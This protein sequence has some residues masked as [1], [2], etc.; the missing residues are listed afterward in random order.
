[1]IILAS[2]DGASA[3]ARIKSG[4][5][6]GRADSL[7]KFSKYEI[8]EYFSSRTIATVCQF[9]FDAISSERAISGRPVLGFGNISFASGLPTRLPNPAAGIRTRGVK[10]TAIVLS[11]NHPQIT[12]RAVRSVIELGVADVLLVHNGSRQDHVAELKELFP[13]IEHF[14]ISINQGYSGGVNL[15]L[16]RA[17]EKWD[18]CIFMSN[19]CVMESLPEWTEEP[20]VLVP[21]ILKRKT[22][23]VDSFGGGFVPSKAHIFHHRESEPAS[24]IAYVPGSAFAVHRLV[25]EK[26]GGMDTKLGTYWDDVD[27]SMRVRRAGFALKLQKA[28][29]L[30]HH[31]GKTCHQDPLYSIYFFQ[32]NRKKISWKYTSKIRRPVLA[33]RLTKSWI[34]LGFKL[35]QK[36]RWSD[37]KYLQRAVV[38]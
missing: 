19:D 29:R 35:I 22:E 7:P 24:D 27:W 18:W 38:D 14:D 2:V 21:L 32:R 36:R 11:Y 12:A 16:E 31:I 5:F 25:Y 34:R 13:Q 37:L 1:M 30:R 4:Y 20:C 10:F 6:A 28:W 23:K 26:V 33:L 8:N 3:G 15:G 9:R 17:F